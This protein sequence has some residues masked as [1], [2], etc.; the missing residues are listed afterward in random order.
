M[1]LVLGNLN[2]E[3]VEAALMHLMWYDFSVVLVVIIYWVVL[4]I[5][6]VFLLLKFPHLN[7]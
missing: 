7:E 1:E 4:Y 3:D 2:Q 5:I 6:S